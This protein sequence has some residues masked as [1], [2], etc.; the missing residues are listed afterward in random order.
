M[1]NNWRV[2]DDDSKLI[3]EGMSESEA[4]ACVDTLANASYAVDPNGNTYPPNLHDDGD[5]D[6]AFN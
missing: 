1:F 6:P 5:Y 3:G 4:E 2:Y